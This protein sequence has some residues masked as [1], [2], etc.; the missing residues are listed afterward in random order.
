[1]S[2]LKGKNYVE[3]LKDKGMTTLEERKD[4]LVKVQVFK[5]ISSHDKWK[6]VIGL[7][8]HQQQY[9]HETDP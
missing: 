9:Q 8:W 3:K 1:V 2:D 6:K 7:T 5:T 4:Q